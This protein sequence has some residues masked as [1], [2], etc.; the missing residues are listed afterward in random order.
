MQCEA[1][2]RAAFLDHVCLGD[3]SLRDELESLLAH[4]ATDAGPLADPLPQPL[5]SFVGRTVGAYQVQSIL[6]AGG[7]G[8]VF[9][10]RDSRLNRDVALKILPGLFALDTARLA[11]F[12][13]EAQTLA[14]LNHPNI[15]QIYGVE[16]THGA[17]ALVLELVDGPTVADRIARGPFPLS[18]A[19]AIAR[20]I[21]DAL[22]AAHGQGIV[23]RDLKPA[24]IKVRSDGTVKVLDFGL[25]KVLPPEAMGLEGDDLSAAGRAPM[26][27]A[28]GIILGTVSYMPPE[29]VRG[30]ETDR[31]VDIWA[32]GATLRDGHRPIAV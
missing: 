11:R 1:G 22:H 19:L 30:K 7:M 18:E 29:Q 27:T 21:A 31:R 15:A 2:D 26:A 24:N 10:A 9:R 12:R 8:Q 5:P 23:H 6:G 32:F 4:G 20:Q 16:E 28:P 13:R 17:Y 25:A 14:S 3:S